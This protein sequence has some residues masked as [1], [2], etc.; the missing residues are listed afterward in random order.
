MIHNRVKHRGINYKC[1][2]CSNEYT[3]PKGLQQHKQTKHYK[4]YPFSCD[5]CGRSQHLIKFEL[6][7][8][9]CKIK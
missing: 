6:F 7:H 3:C 8:N 9:I 4:I 1:D 5:I 2:L